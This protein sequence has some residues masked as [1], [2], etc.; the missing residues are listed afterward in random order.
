[1]GMPS[2]ECRIDAELDSFVQ[3]SLSDY[4]RM[5]KA[6]NRARPSPEC[7]AQCG[8]LVYTKARPPARQS[9]RA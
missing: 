9:G 2:F 1:M 3:S 5:R 4:G 7:I 6:R 8:Q